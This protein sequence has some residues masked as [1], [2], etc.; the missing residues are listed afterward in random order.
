MFI[1][2]ATKVFYVHFTALQFPV[3]AN[4]GKFFHCFFMIALLHYNLLELGRQH[5]NKKKTIKIL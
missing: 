3:H 5:V 2:N 4:K 1:L